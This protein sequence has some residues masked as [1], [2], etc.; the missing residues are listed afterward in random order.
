M[1]HLWLQLEVDGQLSC[2]EMLVSQIRYVVFFSFWLPTAHKALTVHHALAAGSLLLFKGIWKHGFLRGD[3]E[4]IQMFMIYTCNAEVDM[5]KME[6][7][8]SLYFAGS[9]VRFLIS[10]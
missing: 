10:E 8:K 4:K 1:S 5:A 2:P 9:G 7:M 6:L 3:M